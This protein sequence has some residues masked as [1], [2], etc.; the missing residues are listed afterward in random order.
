MNIGCCGKS[1]VD[2][3]PEGEWIGGVSKVVYRT[4]YCGTCDSVTAIPTSTAHEAT[5]QST[6]PQPGG[7]D[8]Q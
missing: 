3:G 2:V 8:Q 1:M 4:F 6:S 7:G 5:Q